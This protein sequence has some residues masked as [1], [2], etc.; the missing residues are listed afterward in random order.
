MDSSDSNAI[1]AYAAAMIAYAAAILAAQPETY[2]VIARDL[3]KLGV[4]RGPTDDS[5]R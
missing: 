4:P 5:K 3:A 1:I 2:P